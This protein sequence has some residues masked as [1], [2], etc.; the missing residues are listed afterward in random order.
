MTTSTQQHAP[1]PPAPPVTPS[2][3]P[4]APQRHH[5]SPFLRYFLPGLALGLIIGALFGAAIPT[6]VVGERP[7]LRPVGMTT[8]E[9]TH[10]RMTREEQQAAEAAAEV[11]R[12]EAEAAEAAAAAAAAAAANSDEPPTPDDHPAP[13]GDDT[14][15][16]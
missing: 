3:R 15:N 13:A 1:S 12:R 6:L 8:D 10:P 9:P 4:A 5:P 11:L 7:P 14:P 16:P 2:P